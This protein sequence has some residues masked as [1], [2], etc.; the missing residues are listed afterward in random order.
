MTRSVAIAGMVL[1]AACAEDPTAIDLELVSDPNVNT[2]AQIVGAID[3]V[4][5]IVDSPEGLYGPEDAR[6]EG[7]VQIRNADADATDL[8]LVALVPVPRGRLPL[9]RLERG[10]LPDVPID[11]TV[12]G[13]RGATES[14][15]VAVGR[16]RG[17]RF[18]AEHVVTVDVPFNIRPELLPPRVVDVIPRDGDEAPDCAVSAIVVMF[19]KPM[20]AASLMAPGVIAVDPPPASPSVTV[21]S[22]GLVAIVGGGLTGEDGMTLS[23]RLTIGTGARDRDLLA[24]DQL[25]MDGG[26]PFEA[27]FVL[28]CG[29]GMATPDNPCGSMEPSP[30]PPMC[31][32]GGR[33]AC[34]DNRC[35]LVAGCDT[36]R[37]AEGFV[38]DPANGACVVDCN[39]YGGESCAADGTCDASGLCR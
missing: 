36:A 20:D 2:T 27:E 9:I 23:Y 25:P 10:G 30:L 18:E 39:L 26:Q 24:L 12:R 13:V 32:G 6:R 7:N 16:V 33:L 15:P 38:C 3:S 11:V 37:C 5:V 22:S 28:P 4:L 31:P 34:V 21:D 14:T 29:P 17:A 35:E 19:S 8:E 1:L